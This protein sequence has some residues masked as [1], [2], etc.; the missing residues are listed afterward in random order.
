MTKIED[1]IVPSKGTGKYFFL[2]C[3]NIDLK[4]SSEASPSF[5]WE[6]KNAVPYAIDEVQVEIAGQTILDGNLSMTKEEYALWGTN[7]SYAIDW[8]L[9]KLGFVEIEDTPAE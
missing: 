1:V 9:G 6:V 5:Y 8:A 2:R 4:K 3:L 7:D